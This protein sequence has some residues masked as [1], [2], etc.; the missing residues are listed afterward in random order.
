M[1]PLSTATATA[2]P[3]ELG[4]DTVTRDTRVETLLD[5]WNL[6]YELDQQFPLSKLRLEDAT[7]IRSEA[8]RAPASTVEQYVT[9]MRHGA[10]FPPIVIAA[11]NYMLVDGNTRVQ[12]SRK[13]G[14]K[15][16]P[17]YKVTFP[18]LN[19]ARLIGAALNQMGGARL[20]DEEIVIAAEAM[21]AESYG[22]E[23]IARTLGRSIS[24]V[25]NVRRDRIYREAAERV[26]VAHLPMPKAVARALAGIQHDEPFKAAV[27]VVVR[28]KPSAKDATALVNKI[29]QTRSDADALS[30]IRT[31]EQQ[32]GPV[33]GPP[34]T[35]RSMSR[36]HAKKALVHVKALLD[37]GEA[38]PADLMLPENPDAR[39]LWQ[40]LS[41]LTTNVLALYPP[42]T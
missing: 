20:S 31:I 7:Q 29:E 26:G 32:W 14:L 33:T 42:R 15:T 40:R 3:L 11:K 35:P 10:K 12:A 28:A 22:D 13:L 36:T 39:D 2:I 23:A 17:A 4:E 8:H 37:V 24:H 30:T 19:H 38:S 6:P 41:T 1:T 21:M 25:R 9:H 16:F 18:V 34:P 27:E 5:D